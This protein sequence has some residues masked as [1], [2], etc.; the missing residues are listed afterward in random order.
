MPKDR[1]Q[2]LRRDVISALRRDMDGGK[3]ELR[4][5]IGK[6]QVIAKKLVTQRRL[7]ELAGSFALGL[8]LGVAITRARNQ[9]A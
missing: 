2:A 6:V 9:R 4:A 5:A 7:L 8:A 1:K 3:A